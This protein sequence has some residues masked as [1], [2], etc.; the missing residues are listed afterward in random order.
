MRGFLHLAAFFVLFTTVAFAQGIALSNTGSESTPLYSVNFDSGTDSWTPSNS[1]SG[2]V[3][4]REVPI[5]GVGYFF[6]GIFSAGGS[7]DANT[8]TTLRSPYFD[9]TGLTQG[10]EVK[11]DFSARLA[12]H[13][14]SSEPNDI[15]IF[16]YGHGSTELGSQEVTK[17]T[18]FTTRTFEITD[19]AGE[20]SVW[21]E[22][23][24]ITDGSTGAP[25]GVFVDDTE[26]FERDNV[27]P[28]NTGFNLFVLT[29]GS[30]AAFTDSVLNYNDSDGDPL[31]SVE[32]TTIP[33]AGTLFIDANGNDAIDGGEAITAGRLVAKATFDAYQVKYMPSGSTNSSFTYRVYD[34]ADYS[35]TPG[36]LQLVVQ[37]LQPNITG[38]SN[39]VNGSFDLG[40]D[41]SVWGGGLAMTNPIDTGDLA[42]SISGGTATNPV[43]T[44]LTQTNGNPLSGGET[45]VTVNYTYTGTPD[46]SETLTVKPVANSILSSTGSAADT[47]QSNN[48]LTM[49]DELSP[50]LQ[51]ASPND[52]DTDVATNSNI[53]LTFSENVA[54]GTGNIQII[55]LD[56]NSSTV[57][58]NAASPG[59]E[60][61]ISGNVL[62]LNPSSDLEEETNYAV[63]IAATAIDDSSGNSYAGISDN[64][65]FGFT[66]ADET[67]PAIS[68]TSPL[69]DD[70]GVSIDSD[71]EITFTE[72]VVFG[73]G[74]I[75]IIDLDDNSSTVTIDVTSPGAQASIS[76]AVLTLNPSADLENNTNYA[77]QIAAA[78]I[79]DSSGNSFAGITNNTTLNFRTV[80][81]GDVFSTAVD[82]GSF[83]VGSSNAKTT[84]SNNTSLFSNA[85]SGGD[86]SDVYYEFR[87]TDDN[88]NPDNIGLTV[89][90][91]NAAFNTVL[92]LLDSSGTQIATNN[93][94]G[95]DSQIQDFTK[96]LTAGTYYVVV[97]GDGAAENGAFDLS[98]R[99]GYTV[100]ARFNAN[101][102]IGTSLP[103]TVFFTDQSFKPDRWQ[104]NFG[105][106]NTSTAQNPIH[107]YTSYDTYVVTLTVTD[108][109]SLSTDTVMDTIVV[110]PDATPPSVQSTSPTDDSTGIATNSN[111]EITFDEDIVFGTG[112]IQIIDLDDN[113]STVSINA[114]SPGAQASISGN[115]L[116]LNPSSDLE[117][118]TNYAV[119]IANTAI[120]DQYGNSFTGISDNTTFN[121][122]TADETAPAISG[123][124]P[125]DDDTAVPTDSNI[126]ITF[127]ENVVF[128]TGNIQIIDLDDD[129]GTVTINATSPGGEASISGDMLTLNPSSG[130]EEVTNYAVQIAA[131]AIDDSSGNSFAGITDN[132]TFNFTTADETPPTVTISNPSTADTN[133]GPVT[134]NIIYTGADNINLSTADITL[135]KTG[136]ADGDV[137]VSDST[138]GSPTVTISNITGDGTLGIT[139]A[140]ATSSDNAGNDD[141]GAGPSTTFNVDNT[142]PT[143]AI[144]NPSST[145]ANTG[146][147]TFGITYTGADSVNLSSGDITLNKTGTADGDVSVSDSTTDNP[148]VTISNITGDGTLGITIASGVSSD[149]AGNTD[150]GAGP[151][152]TFNVDNTAPGVAITSTE[153]GTTP[154]TAFTVTITFTESITGFAPNNITVGNG[155]AS[156][157]SGS[158]SVYTADITASGSGQVTVDVAAGVI[159]DAAGNDNTAAPQ[160]SITYNTLPVLANIETNSV[161][162]LE[163]G[164]P[165][166]ITSQITV[167]DG[168]DTDLTGAAVAIIENLEITEDELIY[169]D[170]SGGEIAGSYD[171]NTGVLTLTGV[172]SVANYQAALRNVTYRN[173]NAAN[174]SPSYRIAEFTVMD[175][176]SNSNSVNRNIIVAEIND[177]PEIGNIEEG[178]LTFT[179]G[180]DPIQI[181]NSLTITDSD[182]STMRQAAVTIVSNYTP[183]EDTLGFTD[184]N[185]ITG[186]WNGDSG[187]LYLTGNASIAEYQQAL[188]SVTYLNTNTVNPSELTRTVAFQV[189][190]RAAPPL[191]PTGVEGA[192]RAP[193]N[194]S[195]REIVLAGVNDS[196][197]LS[198]VDNQ[199]MLATDTLEVVFSALDPEGGTL[200]VNAESDT[201]N[202]EFSISDSVLTII[203]NK[204]ASYDAEV[205]LTVTDE[206]DLTAET[207]FNVHVDEVNMP[208]VVA[209]L[210]TQV[211]PEGEIIFDLINL[212]EIVTDPN[213]SADEITW[214]YSAD[215]NFTVF[216]TNMRTAKVSPIA[217]FNGSGTITFTATDPGG[218][219]DSTTVLFD[220]SNA[221]HTPLWGGG[222]SGT[223]P[224]PNLSFSEDS[225]ASLNLNRFVTDPNDDIESIEALVLSA[226][227]FTP[228]Q[229]ETSAEQKSS[230]A[231]N[232]VTV[233]DLKIKIETIEDSLYAFFTSTAKI[234]AVFEVEFKAIDSTGLSGSDTIEVAITAINDAPVIAELPK[235]V[236]N[237]DEVYT[238]NLS[239]WYDFVNDPETDDTLLTYQVITHGSVMAEY[240]PPRTVE[241]TAPENWYGN[242]TLQVVVSDGEL[243]DTTNLTVTVQSVNDLPQFA[244]FPDTLNSCGQETYEILLWDFVTDVETST[245]DLLFSFNASSDTLLTVYNAETGVLK[246]ATQYAF[247]GE[248]E[249]EVTVA[250]ADEGKSTAT[251]TYST[252]FITSLEGLTNVIPLDY[253][254]EQNYPNPFNP[255]TTIR[256][257]LPE[258]S[259]VTV[260]I[261]NL[262]GQQ[263]GVLLSDE[264]N[265]G[266]HETIWDASKLSSGVYFYSVIAES[267]TSNRK[268]TEVKK[269]VLVK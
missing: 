269:M 124:S 114:A 202:L 186:S 209:A 253:K 154:L 231:D 160:F 117:E 254:I 141:V 15:L 259:Q 196:P 262:L 236:F 84:V 244:D 211:I 151:S 28:T 119:Q 40:F 203:S 22:F 34:G 212:D 182:N 25:W 175:D 222:S 163:G 136:T 67:A 80:P 190:D 210:P 62:T 158:D 61:S 77:V 43:I 106:S 33:A 87:I 49:D 193:S 139:I 51:S 85:N 155:S 187:T 78:A 102:V 156:N 115:V 194:S 147:V 16:R 1:G 120:E 17:S 146:P 227:S 170:E 89:K 261:Y 224:L 52:D 206:G 176:V 164:Q 218:L 24:M 199:N 4:H 97:D 219:S 169:T 239:Q 215:N 65:T 111:I 153:S 105:G 123:T 112:N 247:S 235:M 18:N 19:A 130:L 47:N 10:P 229:T 165:V 173:L 113:S 223:S 135:N 166:Q 144:G 8:N 246:L 27:P 128:G 6:A 37:S 83:Q 74:N 250:D 138:T 109:I 69:D 174:P 91:E 126:V 41:K 197:V 88:G 238:V 13:L 9:M 29:E 251:T 252:C 201:D 183:G 132:T 177:A 168:D 35:T 44:S 38:I 31:V 195:T 142:V 232:G 46:G 179:E 103:H 66:T 205:T 233:D 92:Y 108:S 58:I 228:A 137:S 11:Y 171:S 167:S 86:G 230:K 198:E 39:A 99:V 127:T 213:N 140:A 207:V 79:D 258:T 5:G 81:L 57:T 129:S 243:S 93:G 148:T 241:F 172:S 225:S 50:S 134:F 189:D 264:L 268:H 265:A 12:N 248:I 162:F 157:L 2:D 221:N 263:V 180:D 64:T 48:T 185:G 26:I 150:T 56:D 73:T 200:T 70:T 131:T 107:T 72:N 90:T 256:F 20:D 100:T 181:T 121:F 191:Q 32:F 118:Q 208:P 122:T 220:A 161:N 95:N 188:R 143:A 82:L 60:A 125:L 116:T 53:E 249:L 192:R 96:T 42:L 184:E 266:Y 55:D 260:R 36:T 245:E 242:D 54:F 59:G 226:N 217:G 255:S 145:D 214:T 68:D 237:E 159:Q 178:A 94:S 23:Q 63:Q 234:S 240:I 3:F 71:V 75:Q 257:G 76:G 152:T 216:I 204:N 267:V 101:P 110:V 149:N 133:T 104:W 14:L 30:A 21:V 7:Y 45:D 98:V